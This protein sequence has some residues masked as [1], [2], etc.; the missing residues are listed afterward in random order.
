MVKLKYATKLTFEATNNV[1]EYEAL[2]LALQLV[3][4]LGATRI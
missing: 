1:A 4:A 3:K 2:L